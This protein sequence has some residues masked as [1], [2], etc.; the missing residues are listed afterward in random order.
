[1]YLSFG[2]LPDLLPGKEKLSMN[3][4]RLLA[5]AL[6]LCLIFGLC[7]CG[8][9]QNND[10]TTTGNTEGS[11]ET[12]LATDA[13][14]AKPSYSVKVVDESGN[15]VAGAWVQLCLEACT[16]AVTDENGVASYYN[17]AEANYDV[18]FVTMPAGYDYT[19][20]EQVFHFAN[21]SNELTITLKAAA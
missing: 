10:V 1:M 4:E 12:T 19:T 14:T 9:N 15:P 8:G 18:K 5:I 21:G 16:P 17:M 11:S 3:S 7:A 2:L 20:D 6:A 13:T